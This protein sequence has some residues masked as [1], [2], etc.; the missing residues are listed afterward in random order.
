MSELIEFDTERLR[1]RQWRATDLEPF[2]VLN[3][4]AKVMEFFPA[5]LG[6]TESDT[7]ANRC[8]ALI[9]ERGWGF[10]AVETKSENEFIGFVGLHI[11]TQAL[12]FSPC[13]E[14]GWRLAARQWG[15]GYA[16]EAAR[17]ALRIGFERLGLAEIVAFTSVFNLRSRTVM[18]KLGMS[19][20]DDVFEHPNVPVGSALRP[21]CLY[22]LLRSQWLVNT[23]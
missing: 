18:V 9:A 16:T 1:L 8:Q 19:E 7:M 4:D 12:P 22:R 14:I 2:A 13:V 6:R 17:A 15:K 11:P 23:A 10:W 5:P 3:A 21:H 20:A